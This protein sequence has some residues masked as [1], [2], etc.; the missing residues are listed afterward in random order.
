MD[1]HPII[2]QAAN[3]PQD[4]RQMAARQAMEWEAITT[5]IAALAPSDPQAE[6]TLR[7]AADLLAS[8]VTNYGP[9]HGW[10][11][12]QRYLLHREANRLLGEGQSTCNTPGW[13]E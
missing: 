5:T 2:V 13:S 11:L 1:T 3:L 10:L 4:I 6:P 9:T 12:A 8:I 7:Q